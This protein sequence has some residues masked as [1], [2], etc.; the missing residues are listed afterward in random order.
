MPAK[1]LAGAEV[2]AGPLL[3]WKGDVGREFSVDVGRELSGFWVID[4][5]PK[6]NLGGSD[7][8]GTGL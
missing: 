3:S 2:A 4:V 7:D 6:V 5:V 8:E 1:T